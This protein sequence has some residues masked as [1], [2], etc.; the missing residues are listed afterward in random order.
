LADFFIGA[1]CY[2]NNDL[3][4]SESKKKVINKILRSLGKQDLKFP[5]QLHDSKFN[6]FKIKMQ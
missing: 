2:N 3:S 1:T 4:G 5:S 6:I